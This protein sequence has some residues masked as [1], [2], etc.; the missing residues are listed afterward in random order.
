MRKPTPKETQEIID[1]IIRLYLINPMKHDLLSDRGAIDGNENNTDQQ[2]AEFIL[3]GAEIVINDTIESSN[4]R[5]I[6]FWECNCWGLMIDYGNGLMFIRE[7]L[8]ERI[9]WGE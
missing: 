5:A 6:I 3:K 4:K 1:D 9:Y 8:V 7:D 2:Q